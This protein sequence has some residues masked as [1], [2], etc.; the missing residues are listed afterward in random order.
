[1]TTPAVTSDP[2]R[3]ALAVRIVSE[4]ILAG[5]FRRPTCSI[6]PGRRSDIR[7]ST[8]FSNCGAKCLANSQYVGK[9]KNGG[10]STLP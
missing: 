9:Y 3:I 8:T 1:M 5:G 10:G 6:D 7:T 2:A 4:C